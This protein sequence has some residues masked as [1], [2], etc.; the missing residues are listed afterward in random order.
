MTAPAPQRP[1]PGFLSDDD[2]TE[3]RAMSAPRRSSGNASRF[4]AR[5]CTTALTIPSECVPLSSTLSLMIRPGASVLT[6]M[7]SPPSSRDMARVI[8]VMAPF[9]VT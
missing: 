2:A 4:S 9:D 1:H 5:L 3:L 7:P 6:Q 8:D